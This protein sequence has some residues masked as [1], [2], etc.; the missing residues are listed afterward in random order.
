MFPFSES[1]STMLALEGLDLLGLTVTTIAHQGLK[2]GIGTAIVKT[3]Q[4]GAGI[5]LRINLFL[6]G[7]F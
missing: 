6:D 7:P 2:G 4:V 3:L 1:R 5:T